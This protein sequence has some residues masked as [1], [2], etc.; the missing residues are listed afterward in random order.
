MTAVSDPDRPTSSAPGERRLERPPSERY[1]TAGTGDG[2]SEIPRPPSI[3][4]AIGLG[5]AAALGGAAA[6]VVLGGVLAISAGLLVVA[7]T[8]GWLVGAAVAGGWPPR[9]L[10]SAGLRRSVAV[11]LAV[12][13]VALGQVG[14]WMFARAEGGVL[15]LPEY[16]AQTFGWLVPVQ[17]G[18][19]AVAAWWSAR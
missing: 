15:S 11:A 16:L 18:L 8:T 9:E 13:G 5:I 4:R 10:G 12:A 7:V 3:P 17:V 6:T 1:G 19:G 14:L 2:A